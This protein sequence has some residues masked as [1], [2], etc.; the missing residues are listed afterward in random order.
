ME[1]KVKFKQAKKFTTTAKKIIPNAPQMNCL[2]ACFLLFIC[3][4]TWL[5]Q[6][7]QLAYF[8]AHVSCEDHFWSIDR[9]DQSV[10]VAFI[11]KAPLQWSEVKWN[12]RK[13]P[14][15]WEIS[16]KK[17]VKH[18]HFTDSIARKRDE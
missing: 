15:D 8:V 13:S 18:I 6:M 11:V 12:E 7:C 14:G 16:G 5:Q 1:F 17:Q 3:L 9:F 4:L 2:L 10:K